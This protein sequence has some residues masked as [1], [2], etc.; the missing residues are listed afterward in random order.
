MTK[1]K[2]LLRNTPV[3]K[4]VVYCRSKQCK[5]PHDRLDTSKLMRD[6]D[7]YELP[8]HA[9]LCEACRTTVFG[10]RNDLLMKGFFDWNK[11]GDR[12]ENNS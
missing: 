5:N 3:L 10:K 8:W 1:T 12:D 4:E 2:K 9:Q 11:K 7:G 6:E